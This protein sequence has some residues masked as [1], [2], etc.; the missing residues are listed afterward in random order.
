MPKQYLYKMNKL[1]FYAIFFILSSCSYKVQQYQNIYQISKGGTNFYL[2]KENEQLLMIDSGK[3]NQGEKIE[4]AL[5][6]NNINPNQIKYLILTHAHYDHAGNAFY[7]K[8]K[9]NTKI[10]VGKEDTNMI[11]NHGKDSLLCPTNFIAKIGKPFIQNIKYPAFTPDIIVE[12]PFDL[13]TLNFSG[14]I[15][16]FAGHTHGSLVITT[17][18]AIFV[19]DLIRGNIFKSS[20][21]ERHFYMCDLTDNNADIQFISEIPNIE[22]W[23]LGH[24][25]PINQKEV[26]KFLKELP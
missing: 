25:G 17:K 9:F 7:F 13:S 20:K 18:P 19:G 21:P 4:R 24:G 16:P 11:L 22:T 12:K 1:Y 15:T 10:I 8:N 3:P 23:Y 5:L 2:I 14:T 26:L 6:K